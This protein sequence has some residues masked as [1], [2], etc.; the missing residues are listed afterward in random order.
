[1]EQTGRKFM[2]NTRYQCLGRSDQ[3]LGYPYPPL[4][5][6]YDEEAM[7]IDLPDPDQINV[8]DISLREAIEKRAS[9]RKYSGDPLSLE[10]LSY[11][12]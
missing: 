12:L 11:L 1:M 8:N 6:G 2:E 5:K 4:E 3:S 7:L 10:E 9:V